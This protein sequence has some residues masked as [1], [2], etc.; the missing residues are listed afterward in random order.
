MHAG[1]IFRYNR[2]FRFP[3]Y[4]FSVGLVKV[5]L[6]ARLRGCLP[7]RQFL[8]SCMLRCGIRSGTAPAQGC[9]AA[10]RGVSRLTEG[11]NT[12]LHASPREW[13]GDGAR[14]SC[15]NDFISML[16]LL[17]PSGWRRCTSLEVCGR[18][19]PDGPLARSSSAMATCLLY[20]S[21]SPR[22]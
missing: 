19:V 21:P 1:N 8:A 11:P 17:L 20:T 9:K 7:C 16:W 18:F 5:N 14:F 15:R 10:H 3:G 22:D 13:A 12:K 6:H 4:A 2:K